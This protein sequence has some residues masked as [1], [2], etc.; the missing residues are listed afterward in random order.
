MSSIMNSHSTLSVFKHHPAH[1]R[2]CHRC[3]STRLNLSAS[4]LIHN[5]I[6]L[7]S[8]LAPLFMSPSHV[9]RSLSCRFRF[10]GYLDMPT[11]CCVSTHP[12]HIHS[13]I[14]PHAPLII[15]FV[16]HSLISV[17]LSPSISLTIS[18][19]QS[20]FLHP[21]SIYLSKNFFQHIDRLHCF[22]RLLL[23]CSIVQCLLLF[24][25]LF[26]N[27]RLYWLVLLTTYFVV[28]V[29]PILPLPSPPVF[30]LQPIPPPSSKR[31]F[32]SHFSVGPVFPGLG[33]ALCCQVFFCL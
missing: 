28:V 13:P 21:R 22:S 16:W 25:S 33:T 12:T 29:E 23:L 9:T 18:R 15:C 11:E 17:Y 4:F 2:S 20:F 32:A 6:R 19:S 24:H 5:R 3:L 31:L 14:G 30:Y 26:S 10:G 27:P 1:T 8:L 7:V